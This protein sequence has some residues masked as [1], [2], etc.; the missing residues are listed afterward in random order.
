MSIKTKII[1]TYLVYFIGFG[2]FLSVAIY[3]FYPRVISEF[4]GKEIPPEWSSDLGGMNFAQIYQKLGPPQEDVS[5][6][7]YQNWL[8]HHWWGVKILKVISNDCCKSTL[9]PKAVVYI[10]HVNGW[11][12]P[13]FQETIVASE[14]N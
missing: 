8:E 6:K 2:I 7:D 14:N 3:F 10:V 11:Y 13:A 5:A 1:F 12:E 9:K 4:Y